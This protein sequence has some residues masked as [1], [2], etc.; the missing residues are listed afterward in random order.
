MAS[1]RQFVMRVKSPRISMTCVGYL[2]GA[3]QHVDVPSFRTEI[4]KIFIAAIFEICVF[5]VLINMDPTPAAN[6][7]VIAGYFVNW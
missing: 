3:K 1:K 7:P 6:G 2:F 4:F 5:L